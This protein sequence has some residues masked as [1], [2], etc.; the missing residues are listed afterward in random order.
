MIDGCTIA[1][2]RSD[3]HKF[4]LIIKLLYGVCVT[5]QA[6]LEGGTDYLWV[7]HLG[8]TST[9]VKAETEANKYGDAELGTVDSKGQSMDKYKCRHSWTVN[10]IEMMSLN[11]RTLYVPIAL[12]LTVRSF[13]CQ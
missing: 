8:D 9:V 6:A 10:N 4:R 3:N 7:F 11:H 13:S 1:P 5:R 12:L 2:G